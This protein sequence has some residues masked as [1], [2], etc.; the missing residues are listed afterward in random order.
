MKRAFVQPYQ[1][2]F[3]TLEDWFRLFAEAK[4]AVKQVKE[5]VHPETKAPVSVIFVLQVT[6]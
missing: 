5:P 6:V 2:Y 3:R 4:L 1:W